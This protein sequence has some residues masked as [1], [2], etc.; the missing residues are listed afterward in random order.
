MSRRHLDAEVA[1]LRATG[2]AVEVVL[3][4]AAA[5]EAFGPNLMDSAFRAPAAEAGL[6]QGR[7]AARRVREAW[8]S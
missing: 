3:P 1:E 7:E 2:S 8:T 6:R 5:L 4:D